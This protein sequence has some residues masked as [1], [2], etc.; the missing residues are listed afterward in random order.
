[1]WGVPFLRRHS[2][3]S[4]KLSRNLSALFTSQL[5]QSM[6]TEIMFLF[7]PIFIFSTF[8]NS[9]RIVFFYY[10]VGFGLY[11][12]LVPLGAKIMSRIGLRTAMLIAK[13]LVLIHLVCFYFFTSQPV[14]FFFLSILFLTFF[15]MLY[16]VP[17]HT[18]LAEFTDRFSRGRELALLRAMLL[19]LAVLGPLTGGFLIERFGYQ[20]LFFT[21]MLI[22]IL[23]SIPLFF[24]AP[25][26]VRYEY[27]YLETYLQLFNRPLRRLLLS[28]IGLG[29][30]NMVE[31]VFW[32]VFIYTVLTGDVLRVGAVSSLVVVG[33]IAVNLIIGVL[34]DKTRKQ[35]LLRFGTFF[36]AGGWL[37]RSAVATSFQIFWTST[38]YNFGNALFITPYQALYYERA[39]DQGHYVDEYTVVRE[40]ALG[41]GRVMMLLM[42]L[43]L[44]YYFGP[45]AIFYLAAAMALLVG[46][47]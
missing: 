5:I 9:Y 32:P 12:L 37:L 18:E 20:S 45:T 25:V 44:V 17:F 1:M 16:W 26:S 28:H 6:A 40:V 29:A 43:G 15:R 10:L 19:V 27:S 8:E 36:L 35:R 47:F 23:A 3:L 13:P 38:F 30:L 34:V 11:A 21:V 4:D 42:M 24:T 2:Y 7:G 31:I 46:V 33:L 41:I 39:A 14:L 22:E